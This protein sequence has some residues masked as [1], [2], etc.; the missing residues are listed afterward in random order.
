MWRA[1]RHV[2]QHNNNSRSLSK[3]VASIINNQWMACLSAAAKIMARNGVKE[4]RKRRKSEI[5]RESGMKMAAS[6][7]KASEMKIS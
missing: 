6:M 2:K 4:K 1:W 7:L 3:G 5:N